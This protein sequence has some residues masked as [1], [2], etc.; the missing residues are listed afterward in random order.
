VEAGGILDSEVQNIK[1]SYNESAVADTI[2]ND[3][4]NNG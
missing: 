2:H 1:K 4:M 3:A